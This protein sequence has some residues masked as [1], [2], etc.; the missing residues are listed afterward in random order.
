MTK[1]VFVNPGMLTGSGWVTIQ[2]TISG[3]KP[4]TTYYYRLV[5]MQNGNVL[6]GGTNIFKTIDGANLPWLILM[7]NNQ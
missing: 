5:A 1:K 6:N 7:L 3:L 2:A 4:D